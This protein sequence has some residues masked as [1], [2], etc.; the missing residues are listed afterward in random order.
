MKTLLMFSGQ[1]AQYEGMGLD[2]IKLYPELTSYIQEAS[3]ILDMD[4]LEVFKNPAS[5]LN[6]KD[7]Q[8]M[9]VIVHKMY[10]EFLKSK[11]ISFDGVLGFSLGE[12]SAWH[13]CGVLSYK[14]LLILTKARA[15]AMQKA[16]EA[17]DGMMAAVLKLDAKTIEDTC[18]S[19]YQKD[20]Y[21]VPVNYNATFQTVISGHTS[22][23]ATYS[24][25][26]K[27]KGAKLFPLQ[28]AGAF[29]SPLMRTHLEEFKRSLSEVEFK[30]SQ[31]DIVLNSTGNFLTNDIDIKSY[32]LNQVI[33]P[34]YFTKMIQSSQLNHYDH[35]IEIGPGDVLS[36]LLKKEIPDASVLTL[37]KPNQLEAL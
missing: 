30:M 12:M 28:V 7:T 2:I 19:L 32:V 25:A 22:A 24:E 4:M 15:E 29:H 23:Y 6:T 17:S 36:N 18:A 26:L 14:D 35:Y 21:M 8:L 27:E 20:V 10:V 3:D 9:M 13:A 37:S 1:G 34:V 31:K 33:S 11:N 16:C 5:F